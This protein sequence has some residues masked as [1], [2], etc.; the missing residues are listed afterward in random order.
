MW[1]EYAYNID[2]GL[3]GEAL[4]EHGKEMGAK[5]IDKKVTE[6]KIIDKDKIDYIV[7]EDGQRIDADFFIDCS[8]FN[9]LVPKACGYKPKQFKP[10]DPY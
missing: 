10:K 9:R 6:I 1:R 7:T 3:L 5:V 8:G 2:A 4:I